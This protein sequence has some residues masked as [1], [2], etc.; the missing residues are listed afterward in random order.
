VALLTVG[1]ENSAPIDV[2]YTDYGDGRPVV[3][4]HGWPLDGRSW[5]KQLGPLVGAG[6]RV[7]TYDR[8]GFGRS[9]HP[10]DGYDY[11]SFAAD[12][13]ALLEHLHLTGVTLVGLSMGG[14][15]VVRFIRRYGTGRIAAAVLAG[16]V[17]PYL[18]RSY[19]NP[20]GSLDDAAICGLEAAVRGDRIAFLDALCTDL[21]RAGDRADLVSEMQRTY[22]RDIAAAASP[23]ATLDCIAS[24]ATT[25]FRADLTKVTVPTLVIHGDADLGVPLELTSQRVHAAIAGSEL[26]VIEGAPH[27]LVLTHAEEFN[28]AL[29]EFLGRS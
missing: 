22:H 14:G 13:S 8:R 10:W 29:L 9:S 24:I 3:L 28:R 23:K 11:D 19:D 18:Y 5:E 20:D 26:V 6:Y 2:F 21:F 1:T 15:E 17:P 16:A 12:L 25:D 7:V 4:I 27:G